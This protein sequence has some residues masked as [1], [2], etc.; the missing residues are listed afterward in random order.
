MSNYFEDGYFGVYSTIKRARIVLEH[1]FAEDE[2][3]IAFEDCGDYDY[4]ITTVDGN[5]WRVDICWDA[6]D[7]E[8]EAGIVKED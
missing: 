3:I 5:Q 8:F 6:L 7:A 1:Y 2:N 4:M